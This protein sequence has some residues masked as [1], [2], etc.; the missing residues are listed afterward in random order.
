MKKKEDH[1][2]ALHRLFTEA[3]K[4]GKGSVRRGAVLMG[5]RRPKAAVGLIQLLRD[6]RETK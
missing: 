6:V 3:A 2:R 1:K 4:L 5:V